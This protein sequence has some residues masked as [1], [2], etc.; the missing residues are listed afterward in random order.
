MPICCDPPMEPNKLSKSNTTT[1]TPKV[2][3]FRQMISEKRKFFLKG[4]TAY[5]TRIW[6][7][8]DS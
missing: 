6:L 8:L 2:T 3:L 5:V 1:L 4:L 7:C